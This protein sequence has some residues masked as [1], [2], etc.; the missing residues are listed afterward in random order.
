MVKRRIPEVLNLIPTQTENR[1]GTQWTRHAKVHHSVTFMPEKLV[2][3]A[4]FIFIFVVLTHVSEQECDV[5][6]GVGGVCEE[7]VDPDEVGLLT[8]PGIVLVPD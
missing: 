4:P 1:P 7:V 3:I 8:H 6:H 2:S 5:V